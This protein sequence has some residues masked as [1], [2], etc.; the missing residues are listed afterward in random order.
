M[1]REYQKFASLFF[2][3]LTV[4]LGAEERIDFNDQIRP[5]LSDRCFVCHGFDGNTREANLR[6]DTPE[7][8]LT[9][10]KHGITPIVPGDPL[11]SEVWLRI[12]SEDPDE[13]MPPP[14]SLRQLSDADKALIKRWIEQGA[15]YEPHW[16]FVKV[17]KPK[18]ELAKGHPI[19]QLVSEK[20]KQEEL[21][22]S[23]PADPHTL[24]RRLPSTSAGYRRHPKKSKNSP[25]IPT[26]NPGALLSKIT[27]PILPSVSAWPGR[28]S[29]RHATPT[30]MVFRETANARCGP[31]ATG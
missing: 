20:L 31:G 17:E 1:A 25:Q 28:G 23:P 26:M 14:D 27:S 30:P 21:E 29:K 15:E 16:T 8:A 9:E 12:I 13:V 11:D 18:T 24:V 22:L 2:A 4:L 6:L 3:L 7:G 10:N 19:D 5:L